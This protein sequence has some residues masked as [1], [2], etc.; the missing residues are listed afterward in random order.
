MIKEFQGEYRWLSNFWPVE[1]S[2]KGRVFKSVE[3]AYMS[4]KNTSDVW[5]D[6]CENEVDPKIVNKMSRIITL[7]PDWDE[8]KVDIMN[9]LTRVK[10]QNQEFSEKL[11]KTGTQ[12]LV[13]GNYWGDVFW[14]V[15]NETGEG[16]NLFGKILMEIREEIRND[17]K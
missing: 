8:V 14:G 17:E 11:L 10:Y 12:K 15:D 2:Y 4:E 5:K 3:H 1:I 7:C 9:Q 6:F 16:Q 13:E